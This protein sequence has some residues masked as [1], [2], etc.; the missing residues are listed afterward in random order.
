MN[1]CRCTDRITAFAQTLA[2]T[3][4]VITA[5]QA[6][7]APVSA[8]IQ[9]AV[10]NTIGAIQVL[11]EAVYS[12]LT[13]GPGVTASPIPTVSAAAGA[14][15]AAAR[16]AAPRHATNRRPPATAAKSVGD[17]GSY[18]NRAARTRSTS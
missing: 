16:V 9:T 1:G 7:L 2:D 3:G 5:L 13:G 14:V 4:N 6:G 11:R 12:D 15:T 17:S 8:S 18:R 10:V